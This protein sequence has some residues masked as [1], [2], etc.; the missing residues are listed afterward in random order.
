MNENCSFPWNPPWMSF[1]ENPWNAPR[2][3]VADWSNPSWRV[4]RP[5]CVVVGGGTCCFV[6]NPLRSQVMWP[7]CGLRDV[8]VWSLVDIRKL[9]GDALLAY[10][11]VA[12]IL[13][14]R[15]YFYVQVCRFALYPSVSALPVQNLDV[16][17][18]TCQPRP[19]AITAWKRPGHRAGMLPRSNTEVCK[20]MCN[21]ILFWSHLSVR[22]PSHAFLP[23]AL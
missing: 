7:L 22:Y 10:K 20:C 1:D 13:G 14:E 3:W 15:L 23:E 9:D 12:G 8:F 19:F 17:F 11:Q 4:G 16:T 21:P 18:F 6:K 2:W 5:G